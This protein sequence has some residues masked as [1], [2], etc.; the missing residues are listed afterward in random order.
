VANILLFGRDG[1]LGRALFAPL[2]TL[3][4]VTALGRT[5]ADFNDPEMVRAT[6]RDLQPQV[7][8]NAAAY[9]AVDRAESEPQIAMTTNAVS[10]GVLGEAAARI[11]AR[12][13]HYSTDYVFDGEKAAPY[14]E[15]DAPAP[16]NVYGESKL[17]G[18]NALLGAGADAII[19]RT[20]WVYA[21]GGRN[22]VHSM[23]RIGRERNQVRVVDD[24]IGAPTS[25]EDLAAATVELLSGGKWQR[26]LYHA[27]S[28]GETSWAG[29]ARAIFT[30]AELPT[31]VVP[32]ST[33]DYSTPARRPR[34]SRLNCE[35]LQRDFAV[36]LPDWRTS[37]A[38]AIQSF[39]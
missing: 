10:V 28:T 19:L 31:L 37:L 15:A 26:G 11:G 27:T 29:F 38:R 22:F 35:K 3:G 30:L 39:S 20:S 25:A 12:V 33:A 16:L 13:I 6:I 14:V 18:E 32:I 36:H 8:V 17:A 21:A 7:I 23:L 34:N 4:T 9:T 2:S 24:Q 1:Q 5:E